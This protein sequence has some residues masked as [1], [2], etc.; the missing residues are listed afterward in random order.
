VKHRQAVGEKEKQIQELRTSLFMGVST[1]MD[2]VVKDSLIVQVGSLNADIQQIHFAH[3]LDIQKICKPDQRVDFDN[4]TKDLSKMFRGR[5]PKG[6]PDG[7][8][9]SEAP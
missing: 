1:G 7:G 5:G 3:F 6:K 2:S 4:L 8:S 9:K